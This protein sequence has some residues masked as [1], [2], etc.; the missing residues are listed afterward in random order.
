MMHLFSS[1]QV[2]LWFSLGLLLCVWMERSLRRGSLFC[3]QAKL[4]SYCCECPLKEKEGLEK[5]DKCL[6]SQHSS[7]L[8]SIP[9]TLHR[10]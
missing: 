1:M 8:I 5:C 10:S 2:V 4:P 9:R 7:H 3:I 6:K